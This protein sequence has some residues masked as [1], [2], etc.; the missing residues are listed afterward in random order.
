MTAQSQPVSQQE[1]NVHTIS[2]QQFQ[3]S[4]DNYQN[5]VSDV[6][7]L[8]TIE[9][10]EGDKRKTTKI[11][12]QNFNGPCSFIAICNILI[13]RGALEIL[14]PERKT[15][16]YEFLSQLI[17]EHLLITCPDVDISAALEIMPCTQ[18]GMDLNPLFTGAKSF[19]PNGTGGELKLFEQ[20]GIDLIHGWLVDP[21]SP[22]AEAISHTADYDSAVMLIAEADHVTQGRFVVDE[23]DI[24][25]AES[26]KSPV[27]SDEERAKIE[28]AT[29]IRR[30][31]DNTQ[32]QL[33]YHGLFHLA[34]TTKPGALMALF[35]NLHLSVL[36]KRD[37]PEDTSLYNLVTDYIFLNE[38]SIVWERIEDVQGS[39]STFVDSSFIKSS[40]AGGDFAGQTAEEALRA[41]EMAQGEFYP[42]DPAEYVWLHLPFLN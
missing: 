9:F 37:T 24:P 7:Y 19:R 23:S 5:S 17:A 20:V 36:Y 41:A 21:E 15:V 30:F 11:I 13:L 16:S 28:N 25:Q 8:K 6:W 34:S 3:A 2:Q 42:S 26:S 27:Y 33:T 35:R 40:P 22:E 14:P 39:M 32:S 1:T 12:T 31:L 4:V 38:P 18:K 29:S 10:G